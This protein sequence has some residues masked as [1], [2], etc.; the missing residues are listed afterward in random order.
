MKALST[1]MRRGVK[2]S[3]AYL[4]WL[5]L[6]ALVIASWPVSS[7]SAANPSL[8]DS[9]RSA[10]REQF[11][12]QAGIPG[13]DV[14]VGEV[15]LSEPAGLR[16]PVEVVRVA[17]DGA[18]RS[19]RGIP[20]SIY[21][22]D[23]EGE[24]REVRGSV[25]VSVQ[26]PVVVSA[27]NVPAGAIVSREDVAVRM[28]EYTSGSD[29]VLH[30]LEEALGKKAR[31]QLTGGVPIRREYMEDPSALR[32]GDAVTIVAES[33]PVRITGKGTALQAAGIGDT[34]MVKNTASGREM[35]GRLFEGRV[36][37]VD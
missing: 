24:T 9:A 18:I 28:R 13:T 23:A 25:D 12:E 3:P 7:R 20:V 21:V 33:G 29:G 17:T 2:S 35:A 10:I 37:R 30:T 16:G 22:R 11:R 27:R 36:V 1:D 4:P 8:S 34:V 31:W 15:R 32:R 19:G 14:F 5:V 6:L 26:A